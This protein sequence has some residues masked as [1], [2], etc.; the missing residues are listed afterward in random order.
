MRTRFAI[1]AALAALLLFGLARPSPAQQ[2]AGRAQPQPS[3]AVTWPC[4]CDVNGDGLVGLLDLV[5]VSG[6]YNASG[7]SPHGRAPDADVNDDGVV[8]LFDLVL[9]GRYY[10]QPC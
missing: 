1:I 3:E 7:K 2:M 10:G 6:A 4:K 8:N 9:I 5:R